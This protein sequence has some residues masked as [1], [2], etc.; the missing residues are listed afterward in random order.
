MYVRPE[1]GAV[2]ALNRL[3]QMVMVGPVDC[4]H[5]ETEDVTQKHRRYRPK[6]F[7][8]RAVRSLHLQDHDR[9]D[10]GQH[11]I[12]E[13]LHSLF[14]HTTFITSHVDQEV[15]PLSFGITTDV[16]WETKYLTRR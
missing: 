7:P 12:A 15:L 6:C 11:P 5:Y 1:N 9:N 2:D 14:A 4:Q 16:C 3:Q 13:R 10:D 8:S